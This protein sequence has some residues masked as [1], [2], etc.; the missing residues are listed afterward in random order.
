MTGFP[1]EQWAYFGKQIWSHGQN[2]V[3]MGKDEN[4]EYALIKEYIGK[5]NAD[6]PYFCQAAFWH[7]VSD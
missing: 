1:A 2:L 3:L 4:G 7:L 6:R 5:Y